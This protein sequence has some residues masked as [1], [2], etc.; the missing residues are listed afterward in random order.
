MPVFYAI[1]SSF[2]SNHIITCPAIPSLL[3]Y[4]Q[5]SH[6]SF[7][8]PSSNPSINLNIYFSNLSSPSL[9]SSFV[10]IL[11]SFSFA[12]SP[13]LFLYSSIPFFRIP[14]HSLYLPT[15]LPF[16]PFLTLST[17]HK[18]LQRGW[19]W[20]SWA[21]FHHPPPTPKRCECPLPPCRALQQDAPPRSRPRQTGGR[22]H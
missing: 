6:S 17:K 21:A 3:H 8:S 7:S 10:S 19:R 11:S 18:Y 22:G 20:Q 9:F 1:L 4:F 16:L 15:P 14:S 12:L 13:N 5:A 2:L